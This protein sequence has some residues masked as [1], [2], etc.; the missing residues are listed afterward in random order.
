MWLVF[1]VMLFVPLFVTTHKHSVI[2]TLAPH[3]AHEALTCWCRL[4]KDPP[5]FLNSYLTAG[6]GR[7]YA[8]CGKVS[9]VHSAVGH[10]H[11]NKTKECKVTHFAL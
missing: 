11:K 3:G 2:F 6:A 1:I 7:S 5:V 4:V 10:N 9:S 8:V